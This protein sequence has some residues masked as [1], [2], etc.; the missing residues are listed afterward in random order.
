M[1]DRRERIAAKRR[2]LSQAQQALL[3]Q[4]LARAGAAARPQAGAVPG[5]G[6]GAQPEVP[7][8]K[9]DVKPKAKDD[10]S[11]AALPTVIPD[12]ASRHQPFPLADIQQAYWLGRQAAFELGNVA[13]HIYVEIERQ[14]LDI[15]RLQSAWRRLVARHEMLRAIVLPDGMQRILP[16][17]PDYE[18]AVTDLGALDDAAA[19][20]ALD[21]L[22]DRLSH[23]VLSV[24]EW[25]LFELRATRLAGDRVRVHLGIDGIVG[26]AW[27][28]SILFRELAALYAEPATE[29]PALELSFRDY[30]L[31]REALKRSPRYEAARAYWLDRVATL[32]P[33]PRWPMTMAMSALAVPRFR[34]REGRLRAPAWASLRRRAGQAGL[35]PTAVLLTA[36]TDTVGTWSESHHF[37]VSVTQFER[38][39]LHPQVAEVVGDFSSFLLLE[40]DAAGSATFA[41]RARATQRQM[42]ADMEHAYVN[43]VEVLRELA[44]VQGAA[45]AS[46]P[47]VF[48]SVLNQSAAEGGLID[49]LSSIGDIVTGVTQTSQVWLD[50]QVMAHYGELRLFWDSVDELFPPGLLDDAFAA[51]CGVLERLAEGDAAWAQPPLALLPD[52]QRALRAQVNDTGRE[53]PRGPL[54]RALAI[55]ARERGDQL[56][57]AA[58]AGEL[59][60]ATLYRRARQLARWL[61]DAGAQARS[62]VAIVMEKGWEQVVAVCGILQ[63]GAAYLPIDPAAPAA[64]VRELLAFSE[65]AAIVTQ[66]GPAAR[67]TWPAGTP[68]V[69]L[70]Q[71]WFERAPGALPEPLSDEEIEALAPRPDDLAVVIPTSGSTGRPKLV[72][73]SHAG[74][75]NAVVDLNHRLG[76]GA[77]D[78]ALAITAL[79]HDMSAYD[80]FGML[81]AGGTLVIPD[82]ARDRDP[83]HWAEL[84]AARG[85]TMWTSVPA[86]M[87]MLVE[88][89]EA[90]PGAALGSL[91]HVLLGGD[92]IPVSLPDRIRALAG[93]QVTS[94]GGPTET[95]ICSVIY[96]IGDVDPG[97]P[98][99]PYGKPLANQQLHVLN[100]ALADCPTWVPGEICNTGLGVARGYWN[101][102]DSTGE[103]FLAHS[104]TSARLYRTGDCGRYLPDGNIEF[105]GRLDFQIKLQGQ[106]IEP[107][108]IE[109]TLERHPAVR[110]A[111]VVARQTREG[112]AVLVGYV[113]P[114]VSG[115]GTDADAE[116]D[117]DAAASTLMDLDALRAYARETLPAHMVPAV[118]V[119]L[120]VLPLTRNGKVDRGALPEPA[121]DAPGAAGESF[122]APRTA[123][124]RDVAAIVARVMQ[125]SPETVSARANL[126]Q[127]GAN[128][129]N[130]I[131]ILARIRVELGVELGVAELFET[132]TVEALAALVAGHAAAGGDRARALPPITPRADAGAYPLSFAQRRLWYLDLLE[133]GSP[134]F[135]INGYVRLRGALDVDALERSL[136][137]LTQRHQV[138]GAV[139]RNHGGHPVQTV[140]P[141]RVA[142]THVDLSG[143]PDAERTREI[144]TR[145][146]ADVRAPFDITQGPLVRHQLVRFAADD[147]ALITTTHHLVSDAWSLGL[148]I[149]ELAAFYRAHALGTEPEVA[150]LPIQYA[151]YA[152]WEAHVLSGPA[153]DEMLSYWRTSL[154]DTPLALSLP[155]DRPRAGAAS[156]EGAMCPVAISEELTLAL[157]AMGQER[158]ATL[159]MVLLA[160]YGVLLSK[161]ADQTRLVV[162]TPV[163]NRNAPETEALLGCFVN[164]LPLSLDMAGDPSFL[165]LLARVRETVVGGFAHQALP[166]E[167][168]V[169]VLQ[170]DRA[171]N[172]TPIFQVV[173]QLDNVPTPAIE[174]PDLRLELGTVD[175]GTVRYDAALRLVRGREGL[176]GAMNYRISLWDQA[177]MARMMDAYL[178]TLRWL[179]AHPQ[180]PISA[181]ALVTPSAPL[182]SVASTTFGA[183]PMKR[184]AV[185]LNPEQLVTFAPAPDG[186]GLP[187]LVTP[188]SIDVDLPAWIARH[189]ALIDDKLLAHGALLFRGFGI[190]SVD[191]FRAFSEA[192][193]PAL[194]DY[195][196]RTS[197]RAELGG[198]IFSSTEYPA[199]HAIHFHNANSYS[200]FWPMKIWFG[201]MVVAEQGGKT[202]IADCRRVLDLLDPGIVRRFEEGGILYVRNF[203]KGV[204]LS[205]QETFRTE[206]RAEVDRYCEQAG[207][208]HEW[209]SPDHLRTRQVRQAVAVHPTTGERVWFNQVHLF[210]ISML[211]ES[212]AA[213][214]VSGFAREDLP[215]NSYYGD[216]GE[217]ERSV[218]D[219]IVAAYDGAS[220]RLPWQVGD[221]MLLDNMLVAH[222]REPYVGDRLITVA[223]SGRRFSD[224]ARAV[225]RG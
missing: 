24:H 207:I 85:V 59:S 224:A 124:E 121:V 163:A 112:G 76:V 55:Q 181:L 96:P 205:W 22:R 176:A 32:P 20:A 74:C 61:R 113:V 18:I 94:I 219:A 167:K 225:P 144:E 143:L 3:E 48:T 131:Q 152:A 31:A 141:A 105:L 184:K 106:R 41:D 80:I 69:I 65:V 21:E 177:T 169:E 90:R 15:E 95:S 8:G 199:E 147:H 162:G 159:F 148:L 71:A 17:V 63:A 158:G 11:V 29:L 115:A 89:A 43:G 98:S 136:A 68:V 37:T 138:L 12:P 174:L 25:P 104:V 142:M 155:T 122:V 116:T 217:I 151:D 118:F 82:P 110:A 38:L 16:G 171:R 60:Y 7:E 213:S 128:S 56:A 175:W 49:S 222:A 107:A 67:F 40:V 1:S 81:E 149:A 92:W 133:P 218:L 212:A 153:L 173:L 52:A 196:E 210:H 194:D 189:R 10:A 160:A 191:A 126:F 73:L 50:C 211:E 35:T 57:V 100:H 66:P 30:V 166:F 46:M 161:L 123:A 53:P 27:S 157:E 77:R 72:M 127:L 206:D 13:E 70:D 6:A 19:A 220:V 179:A 223:F 137:D 130:V 187:G 156:H 178:A 145:C 214:F 172:L 9:D 164:M 34:R 139:F 103:K 62:R 180:T 114:R 134:I 87:Q 102:A 78:R 33:A 192:L 84:V 111:V 129:I 200:H 51:Y 183:R 135:N 186:A 132:P 185:Q 109:R 170:P 190:D 26:D 204:G 125:R 88:H 42:W 44:R 202:P 117:A 120:D 168:L 216:G 119:V 99:I 75:L 54:H 97:W 28:L 91:R 36:F 4:R 108:E 193:S 201:C 198:K 146:R 208:D 58:A 215:V 64:R 150:E 188:A 195:D 86:F 45:S 154:A 23:Q 165:D 209:V 39:P 182:P 14:G 93:C 140:L 2:Q 203:M 83:A 47:V 101:D 197:P 221:V 79:H 5:S